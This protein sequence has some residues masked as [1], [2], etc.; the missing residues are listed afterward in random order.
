MP[1][2][3]QTF[4]VKEC[5]WAQFKLKMLGRTILGLK[6]FEFKTAVE[7]ELLFAAGS[8]AIDVQEGNESAGGSITILKFE[9]DL[10]ND[11]AAAAGYRSILHVPH[12]LINITGQFKKDAGSITRIIEVPTLAFTDASIGMQQNAKNTE[13]SLPFIAP[14]ILFK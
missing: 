3:A 2:Q 9:Y 8:I 14:I 11:A 6:G 13:V 12:T 7:K 5:A 4:N 1:T 10:L